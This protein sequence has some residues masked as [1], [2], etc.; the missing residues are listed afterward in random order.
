MRACDYTS[1]LHQ[2]VQAVEVAR[3][4]LFASLLT[5]HITTDSFPPYINAVSR[6]FDYSTEYSQLVKV[7]TEL[8]NRRYKRERYSPVDFVRTQKKRMLG[9]PNTAEVS[10]SHVERQNLTL[11]MSSRRL[12]RLTN[13]FSKKLENLEAAMYLHFAY[14]NSVRTHRTTRTTPTIKAGI[15]DRIWT[16][17]D[18]LTY[19]C[20][21]AVA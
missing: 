7:Y 19:N 16:L 6:A 20:L 21:G 18:I 14:Y 10:T 13:A 9:N 2:K 17:A 4:L 5:V 11:R 15:S 8:K 3:L 12:T 1:L